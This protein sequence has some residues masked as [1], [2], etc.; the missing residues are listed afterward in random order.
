MRLCV[1]FLVAN[2]AGVMTALVVAQDFPNPSTISG[3]T[4]IS[5]S[6]TLDDGTAP[7]ERVRVELTCNSAPTPL[8]WTE[9]NGRFS[10]QLGIDDRD[11]PSD[12]TNGRGRSFPIDSLPR[13]LEGCDIRGA[14]QGYRSDVVSLSGHRRLDS[15]DVGTIVL[16]RLPKVEGLTISATT[17]M[18]PDAA[19]KALEKATKALKKRNPDEAEKELKKAVAIYP[20]YALAW[21]NLGRVYESRNHL[22]EATDTYRHSVEADDKY[23]YPYERLYI[24]AAHEEQWPQVR[25][26]TKSVLRLDPYDFPRAYYFSALANLNLNDLDTAEKSAREAVK[27][28]LAANP[29]AGYILGVILARQQNL[30]EAADL[31]RA[32]LKAVPNSGE[33]NMVKRQLAELQKY[34]AR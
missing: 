2:A 7:P 6:F 1:F 30:V 19:R 9:S 34:L 27:L 10:V 26:L 8:V 17:A 4:A 12:L 24:L 32:Y 21:F 23:L 16:H 28:D 11:D 18:A 22:K 5:G 20:R 29:R 3:P 31:L 33:V 15:P 25:E 13:N 14:L